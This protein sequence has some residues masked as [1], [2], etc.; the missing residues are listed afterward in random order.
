[1]VPSSRSVVAS[2]LAFVRASSTRISYTAVPNTSR[3]SSSSA[4]AAVWPAQPPSK[5]VSTSEFQTVLIKD[6]SLSL[7]PSDTEYERLKWPSEELKEKAK[8]KIFGDWGPTDR[9]VG[10]VIH[11]WEPSDPK[12]RSFLDIPILLVEIQNQYVAIPENAVVYLSEKNRDLCESETKNSKVTSKFNE[13][14]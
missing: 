10:D 13:V 4:S 8:N 6:V 2:Q 12:Y 5:Q 7:L 3:R 11:R 9:M 14:C 1:M